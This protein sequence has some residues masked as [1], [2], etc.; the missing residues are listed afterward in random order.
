MLQEDKQNTSDR[1]MDTMLHTSQSQNLPT[2]TK[3][4]TF[5][6]KQARILLG[7]IFTVLLLF[8]GIAAHNWAGLS[9]LA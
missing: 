6:P 3:D 4:H 9:A 5:K 2:V 7:V 8:I 1:I